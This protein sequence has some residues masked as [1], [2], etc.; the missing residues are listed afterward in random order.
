[1]AVHERPAVLHRPHV[2]VVADAPVAGESGGDG[3]VAAVHRD[4]VDVHVDQEVALCG[5]PVDLDDLALLGLA[6]V[7]QRLR[8]L[9]IVLEQQAVGREGVEDAVAEGVA[10]LVVGHPAMQRQRGDEDDVVDA[11]R[12]GLVEHGL[13]HAP[14]HVGRAH[15]RQREGDV[16]EGDR[17][18]HPRPQQRREWLGIPDG[19]LEGVLD[20]RVGVGQRGDGLGRVDD[21]AA[22]REALEPEALAVPEQRRWRRAVD[23]Q[24]EPRP[25]THC[26][27]STS[28]PDVAVGALTS[29]VAAGRPALLQPPA[30][31]RRSN[32]T[33][34]A[35]RRPA[36]AAWRTASS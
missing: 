28:S 16:V 7:G 36:F 25:R 11:G 27:A 8:V 19:V 30:V 34:T 24:D 23:L 2:V 15:R 26:A 32:T 21:P 22:R 35:P 17:Q 14:A 31:R 9:G 29:A 18:P 12:G 3:L 6:E 4:E 10:Q 33:F 13:D 1:M 5:A 20:G